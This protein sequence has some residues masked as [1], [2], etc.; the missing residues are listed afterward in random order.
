MPQLL[1]PLAYIHKKW[2]G[3]FFFEQDVEAKVLLVFATPHT[4]PGQKGLY[5]H[6]TFD[7]DAIS[8]AS[9]KKP[10]GK[11]PRMGTRDAM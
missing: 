1:K 3:N 2:P 9:Y 4:Q 7:F 11:S 6:C 8:K 5:Q 10:G